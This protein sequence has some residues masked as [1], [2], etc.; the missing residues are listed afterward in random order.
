MAFDKYL[1]HHSD[2]ALRGYIVNRL[3]PEN[4]CLIYE[5]ISLAYLKTLITMESKEA[6]ESEHHFTLKLI[7]KEN[8]IATK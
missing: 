6:F 3:N 1:L 5:E 8:K 2:E 4:S 7:E